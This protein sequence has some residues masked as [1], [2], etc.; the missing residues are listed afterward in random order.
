VLLSVLV[1]YQRT[2]QKQYKKKKSKGQKSKGKP[3]VESKGLLQPGPLLSTTV[4]NG[5]VE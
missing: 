5:P 3:K 1:G 4:G 2:L